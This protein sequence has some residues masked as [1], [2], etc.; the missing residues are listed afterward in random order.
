MLPVAV[1]LAG[2]AVLALLVVLR[3]RRASARPALPAPPP[4]P[5]SVPAAMPLVVRPRREAVLVFVHGFAGFG[6]LRLGPARASYFRG[7]GDHLARRGFRC[8]FASLPPVASSRARGTELARLVAELGDVDVHLVAHS[9]GGLDARWMLTNVQTNVRSLVTIATP[10]RGTPLA[11]LGSVVLGRPRHDAQ[12]GLIGAVADL[13]RGS[14]APN[15]DALVPGV[16]CAS[17]IVDP[18][19]GARGVRPLLRPTHRLIEALH[20]ANDGVVPRASQ[21]WG[22]VLGTVDGDHCAV[23][24]WAHRSVAP[25]DAPAFYGALAASLLEGEP[26]LAAWEQG[27]ARIASVERLP[28]A[29]LSASGTPSAERS[30]PGSPRPSLR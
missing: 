5:E 23:L 27:R 18:S 25:F 6:E 22:T 17:V 1:L 14:L 16:A 10:H 12:L 13:T 30:S 24:G 29:E 8:V 26:S 21:A 3:L 19:A 2:I 9:M 11:D 7:V 4:A 20:G 28:S 15:A